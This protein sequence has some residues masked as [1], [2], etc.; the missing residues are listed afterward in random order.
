MREENVD[1]SFTCTLSKPNVD[2]KWA[3]GKS[4]IF[5]DDKK[6][7]ISSVDCEYTL[8]VK[9]VKPDDESDYTVT[10]KSKKST[11]QLFLEGER[12]PCSTT[13]LLW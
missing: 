2:V 3:K 9:G 6:Y 13:W 5:T 1:A 4:P 12:T 10:V 8:L 7:S 11:A